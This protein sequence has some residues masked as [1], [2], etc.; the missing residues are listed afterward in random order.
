MPWDFQ[1][2]GSLGSEKAFGQRHEG[3]GVPAQFHSGDKGKATRT[4]SGRQL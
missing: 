3:E 2:G 1:Q 4:G